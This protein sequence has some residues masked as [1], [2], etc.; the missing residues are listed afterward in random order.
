MSPFKRKF[1]NTINETVKMTYVPN[2]IR[3]PTH[4]VDFSHQGLEFG[5]RTRNRQ[6]SRRKVSRG[7]G[8]KKDREREGRKRNEGLPYSARKSCQ[9]G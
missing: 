7:E 2:T 4:G 9:A 3:I 8:R 6:W 1:Q 5:E